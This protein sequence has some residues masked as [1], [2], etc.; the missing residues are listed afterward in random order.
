MRNKIFS[1]IFVIVF[2][3]FIAPFFIN[4]LYAKNVTIN[5]GNTVDISCK[6]SISSPF[7]KYYF[8]FTNNGASG[9]N[10]LNISYQRTN[11]LST[12]RSIIKGP[13][14]SRSNSTSFS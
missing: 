10:K 9:Q 13:I 6:T 3:L 7:I 12:R 1:S 14:K 4:N 5:S 11:S 8:Y 2:S